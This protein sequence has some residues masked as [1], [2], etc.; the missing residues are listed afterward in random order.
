MVTKKKSTK[1]KSTKKK[2]SK[3]KTIGNKGLKIENEDAVRDVNSGAVIFNNQSK[4]QQVV[5]RKRQL[6]TN[7]INNNEIKTLRKQVAQLTTLVN[8]LINNSKD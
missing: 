4:Y 7:D 3:K 8:Q 6:L 2:A 5:R 1:K